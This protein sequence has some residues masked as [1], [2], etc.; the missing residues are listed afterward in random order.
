MSERFWER[1]VPSVQQGALCG[2]VAGG[3]V[4]LFFALDMLLEQSLAQD[5]GVA[6]QRGAVAGG[7]HVGYGTVNGLRGVAAHLYMALFVLRQSRQIPA[8]TGLL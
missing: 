8:E 1:L 3:D 6:L 4:E 2:A 7:G 5:V